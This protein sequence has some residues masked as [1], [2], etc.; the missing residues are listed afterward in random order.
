MSACFLFALLTVYGETTTNI[1]C[2]VISTRERI[3]MLFTHA[4]FLL[5]NQKGVTESECYMKDKVT[6]PCGYLYFFPIFMSTT[7]KKSPHHVWLGLVL[8][9]MR[10]RA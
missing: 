1:P 2:I 8:N 4:V 10:S 5:V 9:R 7:E 6:R 3:I